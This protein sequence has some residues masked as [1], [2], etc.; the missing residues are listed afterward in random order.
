M[1]IEEIVALAKAGFTAEQIGTMA[2]AQSNPHAAQP[3][4]TPAPEPQ[5]AAPDM[6]AQFAALQ[7]SITKLTNTMAAGN[8]QTM[9]QPAVPTWQSALAKIIDPEYKDHNPGVDF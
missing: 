9:Q 1:K 8:M 3:M 2:A 7:D 5:Q 4:P 6:A